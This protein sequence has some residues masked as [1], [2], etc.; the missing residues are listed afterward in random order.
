MKIKYFAAITLVILLTSFGICAQNQEGND[1][2]KDLAAIN[3]EILTLYQQE[4]YDEALPLAVKSISQ[5][6][7]IYGE[8]HTET[9]NAMRTTGYVYYLRGDSKN[10]KDMLEGAFKIY[11]NHSDYPP[12]TGAGIAKMVETIALIKYQEKMKSAEKDFQTALEWWEKYKGKVSTDLLTSLVGLGNIK[13]WD[14]DYNK[15]AELFRRVV[16]IGMN[17]KSLTKADTDLAFYRSECSYR[18]IDKLEDFED[19]KLKYKPGLTFGTK[20]PDG[21]LPVKRAER[22][23]DGN[24]KPKIIESGVINGKAMTLPAPAFP[25]AAK[26]QGANGIATVRVLI[27]ESGEV[28]SACTT[29]KIHH[30]LAESAEA[31][32]YSARFL[33]TV[34]EGVPARVAGSI[35][36]V[37][38]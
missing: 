37:F 23:V 17:D 8:K 32:A 31:A 6:R 22:E 14:R 19:L 7:Q 28:I 9:A 33:P 26:A 38:R 29:S 30:L 27:N 35:T 4:K 10:A 2:K 36:Y 12:E 11:E 21:Q 13:Y 20:L 24:L 3:A 5:S 1:G 15:S 18:K 25:A 16:E 34:L